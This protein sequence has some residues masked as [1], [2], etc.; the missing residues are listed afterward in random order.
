[1]SLKKARVDAVNEIRGSECAATLQHPGS[2]QS[3]SAS[4]LR[5][6]FSELP[7]GNRER[8]GVC[9]IHYLGCAG[10]SFP[11]VHPVSIFFLLIYVRCLKSSER[12]AFGAGRRKH[13]TFGV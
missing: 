8:A 1:M 4:T 11:L 6:V 5:A 7:V 10:H 9:G 2:K 12:D 3:P 13:C